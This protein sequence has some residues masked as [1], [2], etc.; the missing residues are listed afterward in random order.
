MN[1]DFVVATAIGPAHIEQNLANQDAV[2]CK[3]KYGFWVAAV[4]DGMGSRSLSDIGAN[5]AVT[6][7]IDV[8]MSSPFDMPDKAIVT[9][10]YSSWLSVL[11]TNQIFPK[12]A[13]TTLLFVWGNMNGQFR[14][15][16]IGDGEIVSNLRKLTL[17]NSDDF[18]NET[19]GL[20][21]SK[22]LSDWCIGRSRFSEH[23]KGLT[24][25][26]DGISEDIDDHTGF[27]ASIINS[28]K[29]KSRRTLKKKLTQLL[30]KWPTPHHT[31]DKTIAVVML[32]E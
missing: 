12:D 31:D 21:I 1:I 10:I 6:V 24:L 32:N 25:M 15:F 30:D 14:Y 9:H 20:G 19:T 13:V 3:K 16:Q 4:A 8:C 11:S 26:T 29:S 23:E 18:S 27:C 5:L 7:A 28:A 17:N 22:K 2:K